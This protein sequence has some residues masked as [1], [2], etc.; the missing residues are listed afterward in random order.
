[1]RQVFI[2]WCSAERPLLTNSN[3]IRLD[4]WILY[5]LTKILECQSFSNPDQVRYEFHTKNT[6]LNS[7]ISMFASFLGP[8]STC[9][10]IHIPRSPERTS[11]TS[12]R[13]LE[14]MYIQRTL[15]YK[16]WVFI[17]PPLI[18]NLG[19]VAIL[20]LTAPSPTGKTI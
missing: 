19:Y 1:M 4:Y 16:A 7:F 14:V 3:Y 12:G 10:A 20:I 18:G 15:E 13:R 2:S 6:H 9:T 11:S 17:S 5:V 8:S